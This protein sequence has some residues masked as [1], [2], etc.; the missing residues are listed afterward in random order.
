[1]STPHEAALSSVV[2]G[3]RNGKKAEELR[4]LLEPY[5]I[6]LRSLSDYPE[7]I[8]VVEDGDSF[9]ANAGL[10]AS[11]QAIQLGAW[12]IGED[13]GLCVDALDGAPGIY[14][15]RYCGADATDERNNAQLLEVLEGVPLDQRSAHYVCHVTIADPA[16]QLHAR[17]EG[18]C[19]GRILDHPRGTHGFGYD[20]LFEI[21]ELHQTFGQLGSAVKAVLSHRARALRRFLP[22]LLALRQH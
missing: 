15:A 19:R 10:K 16:G 9:A 20:P 1:M 5:G 6:E 22:Q 2:L 17:C 13:S 18:I 14:S 21:I 12:V 4:E 11:R 8:D 7:A 3:T